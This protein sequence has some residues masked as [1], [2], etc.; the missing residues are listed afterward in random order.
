[1]V[2]TYL[3]VVWHMVLRLL[4]V[5]SGSRASHHAPACARRPVADEETP[6]P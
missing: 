4:G 2:T 1:M 3:L 5:T 6:P